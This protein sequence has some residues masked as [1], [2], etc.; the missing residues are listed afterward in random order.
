MKVFSYYLEDYPEIRIIEDDGYNNVPRAWIAFQQE[1]K[2]WDG[3]E[4]SFSSIPKRF[5]EPIEA[6][7]DIL[8]NY[9][10]TKPKDSN[11]SSQQNPSLKTDINVQES[12]YYLKQEHKYIAGFGWIPKD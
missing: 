6:E 8:Q 5:K 1:E 10:V 4:F 9:K 3:K 12:D 11:C 2:F 7:L